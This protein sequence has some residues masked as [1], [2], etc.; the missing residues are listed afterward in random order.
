MPP[1]DAKLELG[2][3]LGATG[4]NNRVSLNARRA[5]LPGN[6][7]AAGEAGRGI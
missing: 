3:L 6:C 1:E 2:V 7:P 4:L 5:R